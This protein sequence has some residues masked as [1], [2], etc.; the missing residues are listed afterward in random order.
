MLVHVPRDS[1]ILL[2]RYKYIYPSQNKRATHEYT[3]FFNPRAEISPLCMNISRELAFINMNLPRELASFCGSVNE[4]SY[5]I[6]LLATVSILRT[7][8]QLF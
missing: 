1:A 3:L 5:I 8:A 6:T 7:R 4:L 2:A